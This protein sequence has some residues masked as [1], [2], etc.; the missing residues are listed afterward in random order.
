MVFG[1]LIWLASYPKSGNTWMRVVLGALLFGR[2]RAGATDIN[3]LE[4]IDHA[5]NRGLIEAISACPS[6]ELHADEINH[7]RP[8]GFRLLA[9]NR[10]GLSVVKV[11]DAYRTRSGLAS[12][13]PTDVSAQVIYIVRNP[14]D[15][16]VSLAAH[17]GV[18]LDE[19]IAIMDDDFIL[20]PEESALGPQLPQHL[21]SWSDHVRSWTAQDDFPIQVVRYEDMIRDIKAELV[22]IVKMLG[23]PATSDDV[24]AAAAAGDFDR[25]QLAESQAGFREKP[26][27]LKGR[28]FR[29]GRAGGW[30]E[31]LS[32][33]QVDRL[34][35]RH[36]DMMDQFGYLGAS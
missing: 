14:L 22:R 15:V 16:S 32:S 10:S 4:I 13:F 3:E 26:A 25:L 35:E 23:L 6:S 11:H 27:S 21:G 19:A 8:A 7:L 17:L 31:I 12:P 18:S 5:G 2:A 29:S 28:F 1:A 20:G 24:L 33:G 34:T 36:S 9:E 30:R